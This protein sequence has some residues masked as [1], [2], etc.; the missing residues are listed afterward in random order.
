TSAP[1]CLLSRSLVLRKGKREEENRDLRDLLKKY[2][3]KGG[4][5]EAGTSKVNV[6][7]GKK[8]RSQRLSVLGPLVH[9]EGQSQTTDERESERQSAAGGACC[10]VGQSEQDGSKTDQTL[11][12]S[13]PALWPA[14]LTDSDRVHLVRVMAKRKPF[15]ERAKELPADAEGREFPNYVTYSTCHNGR[16]KIERDWIIYSSSK[17]ALFCLP[18]LLFSFEVEKKSTSTLNSTDGMKMSSTKYR[19]LYERFPEHERNRAHKHC[20]WKWKNLQHSVL[21]TSGIDSQQQ[22]LMET[23][24]EKNKALL[25]RLLDVTLYL[26]FRNLP[27]GGSTNTLD[28]PDNGNFL[29]IIELLAKYDSILND[30]L[31]HIRE[32][33]QQGKRLQAHYLSP[34]SQNEFIELCAQ[35]VQNTILRERQETTFYSIMCDPTPDVSNLEQNVPLLRYVSQTY[36]EGQWEIN[37]CFLEFKDFSKK[38]GEEIATMVEQSLSEHGIDIADCRGQCY[39]NG[40]NMTGKVRGVQARILRKNPLATYSPCASH[41]LNLVGVHAARACPEIDIFFGFINQLYKLF[42]GSPNRWEILQKVL[43]CSLHSL[44]DTRRSARIEAVRPVAKHLPSVIQTLDTLI[45]TGNLTSEVKAE[46]QGLKTYFQS[47]NAVL[48]LTFWVK[49][50][51]CIEDRNLAS[52]SS[53][54][55]LDVQTANIKELEEE[56]ACMWA[57]WDSFLTEATAAA[58]SMG[59]KSQLDTRQRK[60]KRFFDEAEKEGTEEQ[61]PETHFRDR[62][63]YAAMDSIISQLHVRFS[64]MQQICDEFCVLCKFRDMPQDSISASCLK[65]SD[66]YKNDLTESLEDQIQHLRKYILQHLKT[67]LELWICLMPYTQGDY[68]TFM[69]TCV[70]CC[71]FS[72]LSSNVVLSRAQ[73]RLSA[74]LLPHILHMW[75]KIKYFW[76]IYS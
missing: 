21:Q 26:A 51:Q 5:N 72:C 11:N 24:I 4:D 74:G 1:K 29:G 15:S 18:C 33:R 43:G 28:E 40:A 8:Q 17:K 7:Q 47:F 19:E 32:H 75:K 69:E 52:Q 65:L 63:F 39:D 62:V 9:Q 12:S 73:G 59:I 56:I 45:T 50:L 25:K 44:S 2:F 10:P 6:E 70:C 55:S 48:L 27:F 42:S 57:S 34:D 68:R 46:A 53:T 66:K 38:T 36:P 35:R 54:I 58:T 61:S 60:W 31:R 71:G 20:Y 22:K 76:I 30:H 3:K 67:V 41:T 16:E 14:N 23:E 13:D 37:E 64:S 49:V